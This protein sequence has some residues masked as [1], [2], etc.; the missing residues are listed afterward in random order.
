MINLTTITAILF[1]FL[2]LLLGISWAILDT[3]RAL[4]DQV[5]ALGCRA[6]LKARYN[7]DMSE[8]QYN[9]SIFN[10]NFSGGI[11]G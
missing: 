8:L 11:N 9:N 6:W 4:N 10:L 2:I 5:N 7:V 3:E 1:I